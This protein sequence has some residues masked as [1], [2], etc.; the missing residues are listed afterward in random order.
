MAAPSW[1]GRQKTAAVQNPVEHGGP[2]E[3][4]QSPAAIWASPSRE[5]ARVVATAA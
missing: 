5:A 3:V 2:A 4:A 1:G